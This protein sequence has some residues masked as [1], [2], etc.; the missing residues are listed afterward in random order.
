M[1]T[2]FQISSEVNSGSVGRIAEQ[3]GE[4]V[5]LKGWKSYIAYARDNL[6][7]KSE[8]IRIGNKFDLISHALLTRITDR[9]GFGSRKATLKL[10]DEIKKI[11]PDLIQLQHMHGYFLNIEILFNYLAESQIPVVWTFHDCWSFTGHCAY[12]DLVNCQ[13]WQTECNHCPQKGEYPKSILLD[14]SFRN[15]Y[16]K[17]RIFNLPENMT[18]VPVS[19]WLKQ[20]TEKSFFKNKNIRVIHNGIDL[21]K[22]KIQNTENVNKKY[23]LTNK[24]LILGVASP[25]DTRKGLQYF[26]KLSEMLPP[27]YQILLVGLSKEQIKDLPKNIIGLE[28][29]ENVQELAELYSA[30]DIFLNPTLEEALGLTNLEAQACGT[31]VITFNSGGS[32]ETICEATGIVVE[33]GNVDGL[34]KAIQTIKE[35][36]KAFY[37]INCRTRVESFFDKKNKFREYIELYEDILNK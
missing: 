12:Y 21:D 30:A 32:P 11:N 2:I 33:K 15:F 14:N 17:K 9:H 5:L 34:I 13:K 18:I 23:N 4:Q 37:S 29:T 31:P 7:S 27:E 25:W 35:N 19:D 10:I 3:I 26:V 20:E 36:G 1:K 16:D 28:R 24:F 22:F 8:T 6:P